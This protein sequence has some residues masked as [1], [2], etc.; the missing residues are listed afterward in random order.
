MAGWRLRITTLAPGTWSTADMLYIYRARGPVALGL[1]KMQPVLRLKRMRRAPLASV[2]ATVRAWRGAW[3][4][5]AD[6][7]TQLRTLCRA[8]ARP[9]T[10]VV[11]SG[12][13]RGLGLDPWRQQVPGRWSAAR[14]QACLRRLR[15]LVCTRPR[16]RRH[17]D[18][19]IR[20]WLEQRA[21]TYP[22][23]R[24]KVA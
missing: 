12:L 4:L 19:T 21:R 16:Q 18:S 3:A 7:P 20:A 15:R 13:L 23:R 8:A 2:A 5:H 22:A 1:K 11:R 24:P 14:L 6:T 17:Q 10:L 9:P